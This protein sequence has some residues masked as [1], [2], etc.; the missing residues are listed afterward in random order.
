MAFLSETTT[1][2]LSFGGVVGLNFGS[3]IAQ[4]RSDCPRKSKQDGSWARDLLARSND[5]H[6]AT[7]P[8]TEVE[9]T[10]KPIRNRSVLRGA[11]LFFKIKNN[12][13]EF[14]VYKRNAAPFF[15]KRF[16]PL[17]CSVIHDPSRKHFFAKLLGFTAAVGLTSRFFGK[18]APAPSPGAAPTTPSLAVRPEPRA[19]ARRADSV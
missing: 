12:P 18:F 8:P 7:T 10:V 3:G 6:A 2:A 13:S 16:P 17:H 15:R 9:W 5:R 19:I 14:L 1:V 4:A 11:C